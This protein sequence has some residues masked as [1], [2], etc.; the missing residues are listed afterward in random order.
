MMRWL[1]TLP[2]IGP[3]LSPPSYADSATQR[4]ASVLHYTLLVVLLANIAAFGFN[5]IVNG[6]AAFAQ[7]DQVLPLISAV[8]FVFLLWLLRNGGFEPAAI[9]F[10]VATLVQSSTFIA[11]T[12]GLGGNLTLAWAFLLVLGGLVLGVR[13]VVITLRLELAAL[14]VMAFLSEISP[15]IDT[16]PLPLST[17]LV[18]LVFILVLTGLLVW[19]SVNTTESAFSRLEVANTALEEERQSLERR[20]SERTRL[21]RVS[22]D[23]AQVASQILDPDALVQRVAQLISDRFGYYYVAV[24][25]LDD[26]GQWAVLRSATGEAGRQLLARNHQLAVGGQS[27]VG[28]A[29]ARREARIAL[30]VGAEAVRFN[31]PLLPNTRSELALPLISRN[32]VL[33]ALDVQSL[34]EAAF[35]PEELETLQSLANQLA[36]ALENAR[37]YR[38]A[39]DSL[40]EVQRLNRVYLQEAWAATR[41]RLPNTAYQ[42]SREGGVEAQPSVAL[43]GLRQAVLSRQPQ[44]THHGDTSAVTVPLVLRGEVIGALSLQ[45]PDREWHPDELTIIQAVAGQTALAMENARLLQEA[46]L[47]LAESRRLADRERQ[48]NQIANS[49]R[50][51]VD[52][53]GVLQATAEQI[54]RALGIDRALVRVGTPGQLLTDTP[55]SK[56]D[57]EQPDNRRVLPNVEKR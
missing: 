39:Q 37:L 30:D 44:I 36:V 19:L 53:E 8:L 33:G 18:S 11:V 55:T 35:G 34:Q 52:L 31:N 49:I 23:V 56:D 50:L 42:L 43:P 47:A 29:I 46:Q 27:M 4:R 48:L 22:A 3:W 41:E 21:L 57:R 5:L 45:T 38:Q 32:D 20:V 25:L 28:A 10:I 9:V 12:G 2:V 16:T 17:A 40:A 15:F 6:Q 13:G 1:N 54:H 26:S 14:V 7:F 51:A 24:F